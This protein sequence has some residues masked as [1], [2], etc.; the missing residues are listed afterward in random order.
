VPNEANGAESGALTVVADVLAG[1]PVTVESP[2][3]MGLID[4]IA[5]AAFE[6]ERDNIPPHEVIDWIRHAR[7]G[8]I[9]IPAHRGGGGSS[10]RNVLEIVMHLAEADPNV[11]HILRNHFFFVESLIRGLSEPSSVRWEHEVLSG[12]IFSLAQ[13]ELGSHSAGISSNATSLVAE[14]DGYRLSGTKYYSTGCMFSD[15]LVVGATDP[16]G[17]KATVIVPAHREGVAHIDDWDGIGQRLT[18]SGTTVFRD[19]RVEPDDLVPAADEGAPQQA[20]LKAFAQLYLTALIAGI[21]RAVLRDAVGLVRSRQRTFYHAPA[22][23]PVDDPILQLVVGQLS[24]EAFAAE[25]MVL[26]AADALDDLERASEEQV[27]EHQLSQRASL[28]AAM[29]KIVVD[30]LAI[31]SAGRLFDCGGATATRQ[32]LQLDRHWRNIRTIA[33]HNPDHYKAR[34]IGQFEISGT[35]LPSGAFF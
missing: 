29:A 25:A 8:A 27:L 20:N 11:A 34:S 17:N 14:G 31:R 18:G 30:E 2:A 7:L 10:V 6:R 19:T 33:N 35:P 16:S 12:A 9:A 23:K 32:L 21:M 4:Q 26:A 22:E 3:V 1:S 15:Y 28:R 24:S 13:T 5:S